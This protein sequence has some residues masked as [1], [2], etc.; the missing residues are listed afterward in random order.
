MRSEVKADQNRRFGFGQ[1]A[2]SPASPIDPSHSLYWLLFDAGTAA[3]ALGRIHAAFVGPTFDFSFST[4]VFNSDV[5]RMADI[6]KTN[7]S[8]PNVKPIMLNASILLSCA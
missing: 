4:S 6:E 1:D 5:W 2:F 3:A 7:P 8:I